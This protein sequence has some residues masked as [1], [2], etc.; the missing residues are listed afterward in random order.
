MG[1]LPCLS[2]CQWRRLPIRRWAGRPAGRAMAGECQLVPL[3]VGELVLSEFA[4]GLPKV[5]LDGV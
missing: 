4:V 2:V 1:P 5:S 3:A